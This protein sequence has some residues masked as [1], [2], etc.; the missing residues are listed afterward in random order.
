MQVIL[1]RHTSVDVPPGTCYGW[2]DVPTRDTFEQEAE[3]T[4]HQLMTYG[5]IDTA[6]SSPLTRALKLAAYCG[7]TDARIDDRLKEMNMG[8]WEMQRY[9]DIQDP[10]IEEWYQDYLHLPTPHGESFQMQC[11]RVAAF[12]D[13]L[14]TMDY[15]RVS[16]FAHGGVLVAAGIY[17]KLFSEENA[18][19][20]L[21]SYG[22]IQCIDI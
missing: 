9:E 4:K 14:K 17:G 16:I 10:Y 5:K 20:H 22:G 7:F 11:Q 8:D 21:V 12:L 15:Q 6:F 3:I 1:I 19:D 18:W 2:T 13:E